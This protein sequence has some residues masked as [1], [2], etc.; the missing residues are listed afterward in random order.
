MYTVE[1][2]AEF[3]GF[4]KD[5]PMDL[6]KFTHFYDEHIAPYRFEYL[7]TNKVVPSFI[8]ESEGSQLPHLIGLQKWRN[9]STS[10]ASIQYDYLLTGEWDLE[11]LQSADRGSWLE[12]RDRM[13]FTPQLYNLL[14]RCECSVKLVHPGMESP[15]KRRRIDMF[16]QKEHQK[17]VFALELRDILGNGVYKPVSI[18]KHNKSSHALKGKH[19]P[20]TITDII[21]KP[22]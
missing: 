5:N 21:V 14:Y 2:A 3:N 15:F 16:F 17:L 19:F 9:L 10:Q 22:R 7:T 4:S 18:T 20:L 8:I 11:Y 6:Q 1:W 13:E 12:N